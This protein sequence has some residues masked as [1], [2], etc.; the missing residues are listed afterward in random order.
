VTQHEQMAD[1]LLG[2]LAPEQARRFEA[3]LAQDAALRA[4][5]ERL[6]TVVDRLEALEPAAW[7]ADLPLPPLALDAAAAPAPPPAR[8]RFWRRP[9]V[10]RPLLAA[11][12][13]V[14]LLALG[15]AAGLLV[16]RDDGAGG[17]A[18]VLAPVAPLGGGAHGTARFAA[19]DSEAKLHLTGLRPSRD[20]DFYELWLLNSPKDLV[21][22]GSFKVPASGTVD[23][24]VPLPGDP[25]RFAAL[26]LSVESGDGDPAHSGRSVLRAPL[27]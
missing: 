2:E 7:Q 10:L 23:V 11:G 26:D 6:R 19:Q 5:L 15:I 24:T 3:A 14:A 22:L 21:S 16:D 20:G 9:L 12:L 25:A 8:A 27:T 17:R 4:E 18:V 13:A 1:Y